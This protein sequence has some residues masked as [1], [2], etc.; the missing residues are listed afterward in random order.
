MAKKDKDNNALTIDTLDI[1]EDSLNIAAPALKTDSL[2]IE[3]ISTGFP[4]LDLI[5]GGGF[6]R[7]RIVTLAGL[8]G[9]GKSSL[10]MQIMGNVQRENKDFII[11]YLD[12]ETTCTE[13]RLSSM[14]IN[15]KDRFLYRQPQTVEE[16]WKV[17]EGLTAAKASLKQKTGV[18]YKY[19]LCLDTVAAMQTQAMHEEE[20]FDKEMAQRARAWSSTLGKFTKVLVKSD[21]TPILINQL[22]AALGGNSFFGPQYSTPGGF[23][24]KFYPFQILQLTEKG[25]SNKDNVRKGIKIVKVMSMKNKAY[26][27]HVYL[28]MVFDYAKGYLEFDTELNLLV[29]EKRIR[30]VAGGTFNILT[31]DLVEIF[32]GSKLPKEDTMLE[33]YNA[34]PEFREKLSKAFEKTFYEGFDNRV[35]SEAEKLLAE[36]GGEEKIGEDSFDFDTDKIK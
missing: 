36:E 28:E 25:A 7:G 6:A 35:D 20:R 17:V 23:A 13:K 24:L 16:F 29:V 5:L 14:G 4:S 18:D 33:M 1:L 12:V 31:D 30:R 10:A 11:V 34:D 21:I 22:R 27:P 15:T 32:G 26:R 19:L 8:E 3:F 2:N 9:T